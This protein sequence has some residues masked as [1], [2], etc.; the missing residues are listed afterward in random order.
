MLRIH[1]EVYGNV[2]RELTHPKV[3]HDGDGVLELLSDLHID[4]LVEAGANGAEGRKRRPVILTGLRTHGGA[5]II[6]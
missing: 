2:Y 6:I 4:V 1:T 5:I 3:V